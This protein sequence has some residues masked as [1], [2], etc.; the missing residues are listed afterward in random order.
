MTA[1][2]L[3]GRASRDAARYCPAVLG[4]W[5]QVGAV[6]GG[7]R[8]AKRLTP[9]RSAWSQLLARSYA[10]DVLQ[11]PRCGGRRELLAVIEHDR[12][13]AFQQSQRT[14]PAV[15]IRDRCECLAAPR[16]PPLFA[17]LEA[18]ATDDQPRV[19]AD[20]ERRVV[21]DLDFVEP[22]PVRRHRD[23]QTR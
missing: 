22:G 5:V 6:G 16:G 17:G 3:E 20:V 9:F 13:E 14:P 1:K 23:L 19:E 15:V 4:P 21:V 18:S 2:G 11:C 12:A 8:S 7:A 10:V